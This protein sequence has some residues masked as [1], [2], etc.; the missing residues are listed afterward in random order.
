[1]PSFLIHLEVLWT[2]WNQPC[3][4]TPTLYK[5]YRIEGET[6]RVNWDLNYLGF[7]CSTIVSDIVQYDL[8]IEMLARFKSRVFQILRFYLLDCTDLLKSITNL[9]PKRHFNSLIRLK[10]WLLNF[11]IHSSI[12]LNVLITA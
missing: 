3:H 10:T 5:V 1:M 9:Y 7:P 6:G 8:S 11:S 4:P 2:S 12:L